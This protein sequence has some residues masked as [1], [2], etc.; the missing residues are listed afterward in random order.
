MIGYY[1]APTVF[2]GLAF[3]CQ[4]IEEIFGPEDF[5]SFDDEDDVLTVAIVQIMV[6]LQQFG[7][8]V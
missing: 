2:E 1:I 6:C 4:P 7:Q 8:K 3:D 5:T